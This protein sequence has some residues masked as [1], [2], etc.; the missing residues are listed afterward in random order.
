MAASLIGVTGCGGSKSESG[1]A[2][3]VAAAD[4]R[5]DPQRI[6]IKAG[7]TVTWTNSGQ[8]AHTVKGPGFFSRQA[9][10]PGR[11]YSFR[12]NRPGSYRY[13]CTLHPSLMKGVI[14]VS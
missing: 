4:L 11:S 14:V 13:L 10:E 5:F 8:T 7:Q 2:T 1:G 3:K 9:I 12:F 6:E